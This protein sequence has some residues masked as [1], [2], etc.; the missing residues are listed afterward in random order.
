MNATKLSCDYR[1]TG[2]S[3]LT[4]G[5]N[6]NVHPAVFSCN[7]LVIAQLA[8]PGLWRPVTDV[9]IPRFLYLCWNEFA[10][11]ISYYQGLF[12]GLSCLRLRFNRN[13]HFCALLKGDFIS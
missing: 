12:L 4:S 8:I 6:F 9:G 7:V 10:E 2:I 13:C 3:I 11:W 1:W 5:R